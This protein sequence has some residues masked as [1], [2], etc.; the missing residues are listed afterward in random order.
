MESYFYLILSL[1][2]LAEL[3]KGLSA[4]GTPPV[5]Q[6]FSWQIDLAY[7]MWMNIVKFRIILLLGLVAVLFVMPAEARSS[8]FLPAIPFLLIW[9][10]IYWL[11]NH[12]W[13]GRVKFLPIT[14]KIFATAT[15]NK[16]DLSIQVLGIDHG[17][18]QKAYPVNMMFYHH[19]MSDDIAGTAILPT[20][21]G[22]CRSGRIYNRT[23]NGK[24]PNFMLVG[25]ITFNAILRDDITGTWW[26]QETGEAAKGAL[27]GHVLDDMPFEQM[28]LENWLKKYPDSLVLQYD[29]VFEK[30]YNFLAGLLNYEH[31]LP[32]WHLQKTPPLII[33]VEVGSTARA[34]DWDNLAKHQLVEDEV[35]NTPLLALADDAASSAFVYSRELEGKTLNFVMEK[36]VIK[37]TQTGSEWNIFGQCIKGK[38][39]GKSLQQLQSYKQ[40]IRA[41]LSFHPNASFYRF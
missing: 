19:Q 35:E 33:G 14:Q 39:K 9:G 7:F 11:F 17:G 25:A 22:M 4:N 29:P 12:F 24:A 36:A 41:W 38:H 10:F 16:V 21:C 32:G 37:D 6:R 34:Y 5:L 2:V 15:E 30:K 26:R 18:Q 23:V 3:V 40:F 31:S 28:S 1:L 27:K 8:V 20:Y 13:V